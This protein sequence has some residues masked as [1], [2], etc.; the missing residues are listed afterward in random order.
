M[1]NNIATVAVEKTFFRSDSDFDYIIPVS[2]INN[3]KIGSMV[4][5]P[6][7]NGNKLRCAILHSKAIWNKTINKKNKRA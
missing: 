7:G 4:K 2:L 6:L 5:V 3:V 1:N